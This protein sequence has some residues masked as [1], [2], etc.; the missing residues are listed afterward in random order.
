MKLQI[1]SDLHLDQW[2]KSDFER[3]PAETQTD[4]DVL[5][6]AGDIV[7]LKERD[8]KWSVAR[9]TEFGV[10][11]KNVVYVPGNHEY[12]GT[13]V[14]DVTQALSK[15]EQQVPGLHVL[16]PG[17]QVVIDGKHFLGGTMFQPWPPPESDEERNQ[18]ADSRFI[19]DFQYEAQGHF[20]ALR[21]YLERELVHGDIVVTH[22]APSYGSLDDR[23]AGDPANHW[24]ITPMD[25]LIKAKKPALWVHGHV[26][27]PFDYKLGDT[28]V[29]CN[30]KGYPMEGV[31]FNPKLLIEV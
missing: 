15:L 20:H 18:I 17:H 19:G 29:V 11:Y 12:W 5:I 7:S 23:W 6:L 26:H 31:R 13:W 24:F 4:A 2:G 30:P 10:R 21:D 14:T 8:W 25:E 16:R 1:M 22:H 3:F 9:L 28:R 27:T